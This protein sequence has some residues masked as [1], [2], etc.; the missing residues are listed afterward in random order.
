MIYKFVLWFICIVVWNF[1]SMALQ[2]NLD[3]KQAL[4]SKYVYDKFLWVDRKITERYDHLETYANYSSIYI[5]S[6]ILVS[7]NISIILSVK[8]VS[9]DLNYKRIFLVLIYSTYPVKLK[10]NDFSL[11]Q[12]W[13]KFH[14]QI[15]YYWTITIKAMKKVIKIRNKDYI[16]PRQVFWLDIKIITF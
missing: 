9:C 16:L 6:Q 8:L 1:L 5:L 11:N 15:I 3:Q 7:M 2:M 12:G 14:N 13:I 10:K 4:V